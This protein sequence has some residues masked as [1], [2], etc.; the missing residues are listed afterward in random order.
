MN[1]IET[2]FGSIGALIVVMS[3]IIVFQSYRMNVKKQFQDE[4]KK[5]VELRT[6]ELNDQIEEQ[7]RLRD[8]LISKEKLASLGSLTAGISHELKNPL[9]IIINSAQIIDN[10]LKSAAI[11]DRPMQDIRKMTDFI[12]K[13]GLRADSII[14]NMLGQVRTI[15]VDFEM[16]NINQLVDEA[17]ALVFHSSLLKYGINIQ[18][19]KEFN[20]IP[21]CYVSKQNILR[22]IINLVENSFYALAKSIK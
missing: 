15:E 6:M 3:L 7:K 18:L 8:I 9:N 13:N 22:V 20:P 17:I 4:L 16:V 5:L 1:S 14:Q 19:S 12:I 21:D 11:D 10:R 2:G